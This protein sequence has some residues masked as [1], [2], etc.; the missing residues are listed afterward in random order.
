M[1]QQERLLLVVLLQGLEQ[2]PLQRQERVLLQG[3]VQTQV[4]GLL[5]QE[6]RLLLR[7]EGRALFK[8]QK[9]NLQQALVWRPV[10]G[11]VI[12]PGRGL[13]QTQKRLLLPALLRRLLQVPEQGP[14]K[15]QALAQLSGRRCRRKSDRVISD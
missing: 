6:E 11:P 7:C 4:R 12:G 5:R 2:A 14:L 9:Q 1:Q 15:G 13:L 3:L 10:R 8:V